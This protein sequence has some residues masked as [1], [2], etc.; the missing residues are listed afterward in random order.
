M[1]SLTNIKPITNAVEDTLYNL[2]Y[3]LLKTFANESATT[4]SFKITSFDSSKGSLWVS[5][6]SS[7]TQLSGSGI[8]AIYVNRT[9]VTV[10]PVTG[11]SYTGQALKWKTPE[12]SNGSFQDVFLVRASDAE[13]ADLNT[14]T[15]GVGMTINAA[16]V[17][18]A[19]TL[20]TI[21]TLTAKAVQGTDYSI[22]YA[23]LAAAA[24]ASDRDGDAVSFLVTNSSASHGSISGGTSEGGNTYVKPGDTITWTPN[25]HNS[26]STPVTAFTVTAYDGSLPSTGNATPVQINVDRSNAAP[27]IGITGSLANQPIT[28]AGATLPLFNKDGSNQ[29]T[30]ADADNDNIKVTITL[31]NPAKGSLQIGSTGFTHNADGS[32]TYTGSPTAVTT[33]LQN[34]TF[35]PTQGRVAVGG[36]ETTTFKITVSDPTE[37]HLKNS[38]SNVT[39]VTTAANALP[40]VSDGASMVAT[41]DTALYFKASDFTSRYSDANGDRLSK[42]QITALPASNYGELKLGATAVT[43]NK[44]IPANQLSLLNFVPKADYNTTTAITAFKW[45]ASDG[46]TDGYLTTEATLHLTI[47]PVN[48]APS[49]TTVSTITGLNESEPVTITDANL[50]AVANEADIDSAALSFQI[51]Q[52]ANGF[53]QRWTGT[54]WTTATTPLLLSASASNST[55]SQ[56]P[57]TQLRWTPYTGKSGNLAAFSVKAWDGALASDTAIPVK[58]TVTAINHAPYGA[59]KTVTLNEDAT[60]TFSASDFDFYDPDGDSLSS[61]LIESVP[62]TVTG[63]L[64]KSGNTVT[65]GTT[66]TADDIRLLTYTPV[67]NANGTSYASFTFKVKDNGT[68]SSAAANTL[69]FDVTAQNDAPTATITPATYTYNAYSAGS[70][71]FTLSGTGLSVADIDAGSHSVTVKVSVVAGTLE[72]S[73]GTNTGVNITD[74]NTNTV[75]LSGA[76]ADINAVL[77]GQHSAALKYHQPASNPPAT[78]TLTLSINDNG[79]TGLGG[80]KT[81]QDTASIAV[82]MSANSGVTVTIDQ[83]GDSVYATAQNDTFLISPGNYTRQISGFNNGD[84]L[85]FRG[86]AI[87]NVL[88]DRSDSDHAQSLT[89]TDPVSGATATINLTELTDDQDAGL[90]NVPSFATVFGANTIAYS[91]MAYIAANGSTAATS[92]HDVFNIATGSYTYTIN[93]FDVGDQL[94]FF[95]HAIL[96]IVNDSNQ[97]DGIQQLTATDPGTGAITTIILTGLTASQDQGLF[98]IPGFASVFG[99]GSIA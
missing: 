7:D 68:L 24:N 77:S 56:A 49:L 19:P 98:N 79:N 51:E 54:T 82:I 50:A 20:T 11:A 5:N 55:E 32:Y 83:N 45:K 26:G 72:V 40:V 65:A 64:L 63:S 93:G 4:R 80:S 8:Q 95:A 16:G 10:V 46:H 22:S 89:A 2:N 94:K 58:V 97:S 92:G 3:G 43:L 67:A 9:G 31:D 76:I 96:N 90:F 18:H 74:N 86:D 87:L 25:T 48:D 52:V 70:A 66:V 47:T 75:T 15:S 85:I 84:K 44:E 57:T 91:A 33:A 23:T 42:I 78:T 35:K 38:D 62:A 36:S 37:A 73:A 17:N 59:D 13:T 71:G 27:T 61:I 28:D 53:L 6:G 21:N 69:T 12:F 1:A 99:A 41:E 81:S 60:Y 34:L 88:P 30:L 14:E 29:V 39:V